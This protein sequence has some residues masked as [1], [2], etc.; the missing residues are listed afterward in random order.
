MHEE[1]APKPLGARSLQ[2]PCHTPCHTP[3]L[4]CTVLQAELEHAQAEGRLE[5]LALL[6][7]GIT[8]QVPLG[9]DFIQSPGQRAVVMLRCAVLRRTLLCLAGRKRSRRRHRRLVPP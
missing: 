1:E 2:P 3:C 8:V 4:L 7:E 9:A 5:S 6:E